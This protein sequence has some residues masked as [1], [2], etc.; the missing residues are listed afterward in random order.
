MKTSKK[1][2]A[3]KVDMTKQTVVDTII[4]KEGRDFEVVLAEDGVFMLK[5]LNDYGEMFL[6]WV[7]HIGKMEL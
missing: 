2:K 1:K 3:S 4:P 6:D 5:S 7:E